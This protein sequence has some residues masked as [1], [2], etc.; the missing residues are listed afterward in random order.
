MKLPYVGY[1]TGEIGR[2]RILDEVEDGDSVADWR[3][4]VGS[5]GVVEQVSLAVNRPQE[6]GKLE[7]TV[8]ME[9]E[10]SKGMYL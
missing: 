4:E 3:E 1:G 5:F 6:V 2:V 9:Q 10:T 8:N 7:R